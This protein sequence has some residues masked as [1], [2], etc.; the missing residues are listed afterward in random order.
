MSQNCEIGITAK[1]IVLAPQLRDKGKWK[2]ID[3]SAYTP[4]T[5]GV[6]ITKFGQKNHQQASNAFYDFLSSQ[7]AQ[8]IFL[9]YGYQL[10]VSNE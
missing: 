3:S 6:V 4:I 10:P 9:D 2:E 1:S 5:Q 7:A 8:Q